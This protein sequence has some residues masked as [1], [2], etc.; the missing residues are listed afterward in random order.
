M[1]KLHTYQPV[2]AT[3]ERNGGS[4]RERCTVC[5]TL[6]SPR[7]GGG[8][9]YSTTEGRFWERRRPDCAAPDRRTGEG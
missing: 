6:R 1:A 5:G 4:D 3:D 9:V 8:W 2:P 7:Y